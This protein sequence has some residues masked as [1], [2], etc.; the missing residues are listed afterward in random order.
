MRRYLAA[1]VCLVLCVA[2]CVSGAAKTAS[3]DAAMPERVAASSTGGG[4]NAF[5]PYMNAAL[6]NMRRLSDADE[7]MVRQMGANA[8]RIEGEA[9]YRQRWREE[10]Y[11]VVFGD[12]RAPHEI[13]VLLDFAEPRSEKIWQ[14]VVEAARS[15]S[16]TR[17]KIVVFANSREN[18]GTDL[19]GFAIW[20]TYS[21]QGG[22]MPWLSHAL[23][24]WNAVK[25]EQKRVR[26]RAVPFNN[27]YDATA[28]PS[29]YPI[30]YT[31]MEKLR[32][33]VPPGEELAVSKYCY[34]AGNV[35]LYQAMQVS[36]YYGVTSLPAV[37][38]DG[39]PLASPSAGAIAQA[40]R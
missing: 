8:H 37:I 19:M 5:N 35:N 15:F 18:Y 21:R 6:P 31:Y 3:P 9:A 29:D 1:I 30:L 11:P 26:G 16:P 13:L 24:R 17:E 12:A 7:Q 27:E 34:E 20:L 33:P 23:A 38:V 22:A 28:R 4:A 25:A 14:T 2:G 36:A 32:P 10:L 40:L 39:K